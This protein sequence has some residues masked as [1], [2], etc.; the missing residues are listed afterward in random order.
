MLY[1]RLE[2]SLVLK[3]GVVRAMTSAFKFSIATPFMLFLT[4]IG[5]V[6]AGGELTPRNVFVTLLLIEFLKR[7]I[8]SYTIRSFFFAYEARVALAR[9]QIC[10]VGNLDFFFHVYNLNTQKLLELDD[11]EGQP[12]STEKNSAEDIPYADL[13]SVAK[14][15][16]KVYEG[17][18]EGGYFRPVSPDLLR[19][20]ASQQSASSGLHHCHV[21][22]EKV[23]ASWSNETEKLILGG[24][25]FEM[26]MVSSNYASKSK[27]YVTYLL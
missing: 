25:N 20:S 12:F 24:I 8:I 19:A 22:V 7:S 6:A 5:F 3:G 26:K 21:T 4:F 27:F 18:S 10:M 23:S 15:P 1:Y 13:R 2:S 9:I 14:L 11:Y 16:K 17:I